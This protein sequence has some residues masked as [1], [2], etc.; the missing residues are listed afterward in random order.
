MLRSW[1][2]GVPT[3][4]KL[5]HRHHRIELDVGVLQRIFWM[6]CVWP[7]RSRTNCLR[8]RSRSRICYRMKKK[9]LVFVD[10]LLQT[11]G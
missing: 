7:V 8:V 11:K 6:R 1:P 2:E 9:I 5:C 4:S 10:A 3:I